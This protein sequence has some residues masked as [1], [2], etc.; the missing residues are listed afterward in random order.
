MNRNTHEECQ[1]K[2]SRLYLANQDLA[3]E[4]SKIFKL[5]EQA[6]NIIR[7]REKEKYHLVKTLDLMK[8]FGIDT[9]SFM[10]SARKEIENEK[11]CSVFHTKGDLQR[12]C[13]VK[14]ERIKVLERALELVECYDMDFNKKTVIAIAKEEIKKEEHNSSKEL[15][16]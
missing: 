10:Q 2:I 12:L 13:E 9:V 3:R 7:L 8:F 6:E 14:D 4:N 16:T 11:I 1:K 15:K 5:L